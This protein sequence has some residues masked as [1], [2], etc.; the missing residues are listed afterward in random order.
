MDDVNVKKMN[1]ID[2]DLKNIKNELLQLNIFMCHICKVFD[3]LAA[4]V[5]DGQNEKS[6][7]PDMQ[8]ISK[9]SY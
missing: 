4:A 5:P 8:A 1:E 2:N 3:S 6:M 7:N 9:D